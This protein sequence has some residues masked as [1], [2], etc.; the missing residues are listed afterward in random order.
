[1]TGASPNAARIERLLS[2][3]SSHAVFRDG[4]RSI[5]AA[6]MPEAVARAA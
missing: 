1:M 3:L 2:T 6:Y 5:L 4:F